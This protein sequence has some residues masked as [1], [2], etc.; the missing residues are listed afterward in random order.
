VSAPAS[1]ERRIAASAIG[2]A[3]GGYRELSYGAAARTR[4]RGRALFT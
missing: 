2:V 4:T 3:Y 1:V